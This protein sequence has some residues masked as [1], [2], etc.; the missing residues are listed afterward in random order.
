MVESWQSI[1]IFINNFNNLTRGFHQLIEWLHQAGHWNLYV[2]DNSSTWEPLLDYYQTLQATIIKCNQNLG[3]DA[4][5]KL[6][7]S[8]EGK[9]ILTDPDVV[10]D[11]NCP[12]DLV[13]KM[14]E[15]SDRYHPAKVGPALRIDNLPD[16]YRYKKDM[17]KSEGKYWQNRL[18]SEC[19]NAL[20]DTTFALYDNSSWGRFPPVHHIR[21]DFPYVAE[22]IP[23]Y[24]NSSL[25][26]EERDFYKKHVIRGVSHSEWGNEETI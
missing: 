10:P 15:V 6:G 25:P 22:H 26:N 3:C 13:R 5:W 2:I 17:L 21:L 14:V 23:W 7:I 18:D 4:F 24:D 11:E 1:P 16:H 12:K 20:I 19:W 9:F 8:W